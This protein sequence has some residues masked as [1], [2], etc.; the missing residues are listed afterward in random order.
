MKV[1]ALVVPEADLVRTVE[2]VRWL[3]ASGFGCAWIAD[4]PPLGW[5]DVYVTLALCAEATSR[6]TLAPGVTN[7]LTRH[8]S[9]TANAMLTLH[10]LTGGRVALGIG[11][12]YSAV[13]AVGMKPAALRTLS[14]YVADLRRVFADHDASIPVYVAASG[15]RALLTAGRIGDGAMVTVGTHPALVRRACAQIAEGARE[16]GRDPSVLDV[17]FLAGLSISDDWE[18]AKREASPVAAR[19]AKDAEFHP[20]FF[21]PPELEDLRRDAE[22]VARAYDV[23][24]HVDPAAPHNR[25]VTDE[26]VDAL[27]LA[28]SPARVAE[29]LS[30]M[31]EA[32]ADRV[33]LFPAGIHRRVALE[34]F[35]D[36]VLPRLSAARPT[37]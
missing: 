12:G 28:G 1:D 27:T 33:A 37:V 25:L 19:R 23:Q 20:Q 6:I 2:L 21:L 13:R 34:R 10:Q 32:G 9:V 18:E 8:V 14:E 24:R 26:L 29:R 5:P 16:A 17:V 3:E 30:E 7:P 31:C 11:A 36:T 4:S 15:P 22:A 35:I